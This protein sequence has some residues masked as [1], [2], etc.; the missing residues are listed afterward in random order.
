[1]G[2]NFSPGLYGGV[3]ALLAGY[4]RL[5]G[6]NGAGPANS[7]GLSVE[8]GSMPPRG[9]S[10]RVGLGW[11]VFD[12]QSLNVLD[13]GDA[14]WENNRFAWLDG[15]EANV[16]VAY[17]FTLGG[18]LTLGPELRAGLS[19]RHGPEAQDP[20]RGRARRCSTVQEL[21]IDITASFEANGRDSAG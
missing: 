2:W 9:L 11:R 16:F 13:T 20:S 1:M 18:G 8:I 14:G 3:A 4:P 17:A 19:G 21:A 10:Y 6:G 15:P 7:I 5:G 12:A